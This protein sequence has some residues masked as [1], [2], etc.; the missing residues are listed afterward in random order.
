MHMNP[1]GTASLLPGCSWVKT[2]PGIRYHGPEW[3]VPQHDDR[4]RGLRKLSR[5]ASG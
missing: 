1:I 2:A 4:S 3:G 5:M